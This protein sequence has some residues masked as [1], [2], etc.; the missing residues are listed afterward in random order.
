MPVSA[1]HKTKFNKICYEYN[2][3][4]HIYEIYNGIVDL[5]TTCNPNDIAALDELNDI[6]N[7][8]NIKNDNNINYTLQAIIEDFL[9]N[10]KYKKL[11][12]EFC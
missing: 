2:N 4:E 10:D 9:F 11:R 6:N 8:F 5:L 1:I 12:L 7:R 3:N